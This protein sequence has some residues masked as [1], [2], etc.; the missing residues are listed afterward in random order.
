MQVYVDADIDRRRS[1]CL[2]SLYLEAMKIV[3]FKTA[4]ASHLPPSVPSI[5]LKRTSTTPRIK[6][7]STPTT[8]KL[9][10]QDF[11]QWIDQTVQLLKEGKLNELDIENLIEEVESL[12]RSDKR[13]LSSNLI[14]VML[15][16]LKWQ[17][18]SEKRSGSWKSSILEHRDRIERLLKDS[19]S[20][21]PYLETEVNPCYT[22]ARL[23][24]SAETGLDI[25]E[26]PMD[27]PYGL[28]EL[29]SDQFLPD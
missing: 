21:K 22:R 11:A 24:A 8:A 14:I 17:Y 7:L 20:L 28:E 18:Q 27:C 9:Y 10:D 1:L 19:P 16:L 2:H 4:I 26:F 5:K 23:R 13:A 25:N 6:M 15:H 3:G 29:L 12:G